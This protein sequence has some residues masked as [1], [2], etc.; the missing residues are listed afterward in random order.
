M[1]VDSAALIEAIDL[2]GGLVI[3]MTADEV[4]HMNNYCRKETSKLTGKGYDPI[5]RLIIVHH[6]NGY[7]LCLMRES[8]YGEQL[9]GVR[10]VRT[11]NLQDG[12]RRRIPA[13]R[14]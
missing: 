2:L 7:N 4:E 12:G 11:G 3:E 1:T 8:A 9:S 6:L 13:G 10:P 14:R 5:D